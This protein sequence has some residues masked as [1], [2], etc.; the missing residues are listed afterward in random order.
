MTLY[1]EETGTP[2][3]PSIIFI[4][5]VATSSWMWQPQTALLADY[6][7]LAVDLPGH[8][9]S[10]QQQWLSLSKTAATIASIIQCRATNARAHI[11]GL[12][13][14]GYVGLQLLND[15]PKL[16]GSTIVSGVN[17]IAHPMM[18]AIQLLGPLLG[19]SIKTN[20]MLRANARAL[21]VPPHL[22]EA[23]AH[24]AR[25]MTRQAFLQ[26]S[27]DAANFTLPGGLESVTSPTLALAGA[28]EHA[29]ILQSLPL[30][31]GALRHSAAYTVPAAGHGWNGELPG[32]FS[33][34]VRAWVSGQP[35]P[36]KL[37]EVPAVAIV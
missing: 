7:Y 37:M 11:V 22:Y 36:E 20:A 18:K 35:L 23:Y 31:A 1:V 34:T 26:A 25:L 32:L 6:H 9:R 14:G 19:L 16:V 27:A 5:A 10:N 17:V 30:I 4:H 28:N 15:H 29:L 8:G 24:E 3:A 13:L 21:H 33:D 12:S 2:G